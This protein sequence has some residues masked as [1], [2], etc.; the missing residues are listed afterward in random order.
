M[1]YRFRRACLLV[2]LLGL[3]LGQ[4]EL[5]TTPESAAPATDPAD[6]V[7]PTSTAQESVAPETSEA[8]S[9]TGA[10]DTPTPDAAAA[11]TAPATPNPQPRPK[12]SNLPSGAN[13]A[14]VSVHGDIYDYTFRSLQRRVDKALAAGATV[15]VLEIDTY[16][17]LVTAALDIAKYLKDSSKVPVPTIAWINDKAYSAGI[18]IAAACDEI[19]MVPSSATGDCA[20]IAPGQNLAPTERAK[21][22]SPIAREFQN[23]ARRHGYTYA[24]FHAMCELG[25]ELYLIENPATGER[26]VVNQADYAVMVKG[27]ASARAGIKISNE[28]PAAGTPSLPLPLPGGIGNSGGGGTTTFWGIAE[29]TEAGS[30]LGNWVPVTTLPSGNYAPDG[31]V[32]AG[33]GLL[34]TP[35][36]V[37]AAD[38]GLSQTT[39]ADE[40]ELQRY[41][42]AATLTRFD[43]TWSENLAGFLSNNWW[44]RIVLIILL[45]LGVFLELQAPGLGVPGAIALVALF[46]LFGAPMVIGLADI[47]HVLLF[48]VGLALLVIEITVTPTFGVLGIVGIIVMI[49]SLVLAVVPSGGGIVPAPGMGDEILMGALTTIT[50]FALAGVG[51]IVLINYF[52]KIPGLNRLVLANEPALAGVGPDGQPVR[53]AG[54]AVLGDGRIVVGQT[55]TVVSTLR[56]AGAA[57]FDGQAIDVVSVGPMVDVGQTVRVTKVKRFGIVVEPVEEA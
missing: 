45:I 49:A 15:I 8:A 7:T 48:A 53:I 10:P 2:C 16:G 55:G 42:G 23:S 51:V 3:L 4:A 36:D 1:K 32:H 50:G 20:P 28:A 21:V 14:I 5:P 46:G 43:P 25:V 34:F 41:L 52:G 57:E 11:S 18:M 26:K 31:R 35:D 29:S 6:T 54:Q 22:F 33:V 12:L 47:W 39:V 13:V 9:P 37:L 38:I 30:D 40:A 17:G 19:V 44:V 56:P 27:D 24:T